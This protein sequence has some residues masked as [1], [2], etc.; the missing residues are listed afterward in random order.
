MKTPHDSDIEKLTLAYGALA[1]IRPILKG[2]VDEIN[3]LLSKIANKQDV[4][5][6]RAYD[7]IV[8]NTPKEAV[9][10]PSPDHTE[11]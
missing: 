10:Y 1:V 11:S 2:D 5:K 9:A 3:Q 4:F 7:Y 8:Q 6:S